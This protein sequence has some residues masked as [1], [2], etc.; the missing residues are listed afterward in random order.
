MDMSDLKHNIEQELILDGIYV[1]KYLERVEIKQY[2]K[3]FSKEAQKLVSELYRSWKV[4]TWQEWLSIREDVQSTKDLQEA[5]D[6]YKEM[7]A[8]YQ[9]YGQCTTEE[10]YIKRINAVLQHRAREVKS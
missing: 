10:S 8:S 4:Q 2:H 1:D 9:E 6:I 7:Q 5:L 3:V